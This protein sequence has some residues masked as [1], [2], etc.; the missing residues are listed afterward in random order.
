MYRKSTADVERKK[1]VIESGM[2]RAE[3][4]GG[5]QKL[6]DCGTGCSL[7]H[8]NLAFLKS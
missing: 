8:F 5:E 3:H 7:T 6:P 1:Q 4:Y 2:V